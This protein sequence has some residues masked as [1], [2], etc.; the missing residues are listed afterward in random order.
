[1]R[2][3][4]NRSFIIPTLYASL[5]LSGP[6]L[7]KAEGTSADNGWDFAV[8]A[9]L[10]GADIGG[11]TG[12]GAD[13]DVSFSDLFS[14]LNAGFMGTFE[15]RKDKWLVLTDLVYLDVSAD[16]KTDVTIPVGPGLGPGPVPIDI[17]TKVEIDLKGTVFQLAGGYNL[18]SEG[19]LKLDLLAG[20][21]YL[22][23]DNDITVNLS[24]IG[25]GR[26]TKFSDDGH[27]W[28]GIVGV[29]G[30]YALSP[31]WS[32]PYYA[33]IG[34]GQSDF[35]WQVAAGVAYHAAEWVDVA[36]VYRY[37]AWDIGEDFVDDLN[38]SGPA[39]GAVFRW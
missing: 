8:A 39:L 29:K 24:S 16:N 7:V 27:V 38:F 32:L 13:I 14:G 25:G 28:D 37:L 20:A 9:Y 1:M 5:L 33:D 18:L 12:S 21:R 11:T 6:A 36:L 2:K 35:T 4:V 30:M 22:N 17:D 34:T 19:P 26:K 3:N 23:L 10:W 15:A 31:R